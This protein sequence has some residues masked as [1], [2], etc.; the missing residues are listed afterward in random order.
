M[1]P[2]LAD[3]AHSV[4][5]VLQRAELLS[6]QMTG[7]QVRNN[8]TALRMLRVLKLCRLGV[9]ACKTVSR[10]VDDSS[11]EK[12]LQSRCSAY[13]SKGKPSAYILDEQDRTV[14]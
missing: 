7:E 4:H 1:H 5:G 11:A 9:T 8:A 12:M 2:Q 13:R 6:Y 3:D 10:I 14:R